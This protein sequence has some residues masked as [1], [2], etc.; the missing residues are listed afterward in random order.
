MVATAPKFISIV[1]VICIVC[2]QHL[3]VSAQNSCDRPGCTTYGC[4]IGPSEPSPAPGPTSSVF[5]GAG[6]GNSATILVP[7]PDAGGAATIPVM[8]SSRREFVYA[9]YFSK[10]AAPPSNIGTRVIFNGQEIG[11]VNYQD[12]VSH[13]SEFTF[14]VPVSSVI[15]GTAA[16]P[17]VNTFQLVPITGCE[18]DCASGCGQFWNFISEE[19]AWASLTVP[20]PVLIR[21]VTFEEVTDDPLGGA[22]DA[23]PDDT[24]GGRRIFPDAEL[25]GPV[26]APTLNEPR[27]KVRVVVQASG[28]TA[29]REVFL[30][31]FDVD[32]S[33]ITDP[34]DSGEKLPGV[35][36]TG[37][38]GDNQGPSVRP[39]DPVPGTGAFA[40]TGTAN[41]TAVTDSTGQALA[42]FLVT[43]QPGDN[44]KIAVGSDA[45]LVDR[46]VVQGQ[47]LADS[48]TNQV[49]PTTN[50]NSPNGDDLIASELLTVWRKM[51]V[52]VDSMAPPPAF[53]ENANEQRNHLAGAIVR[54]ERGGERSTRLYLNP[55]PTAA[56]EPPAPGLAPF[57]DLSRNLSS[58]PA[59][60]GRFQN[61]RVLI[62]D[63]EYS[64]IGNGD[65]YI[66]GS[67]IRIGYNLT[68]ASTTIPPPLPVAG[69]VVS[70]N[71]VPSTIDIDRTL[72][73]NYGGGVVRLSGIDYMVTAVANDSNGRRRRLVV[74]AAPTVPFYNLIDD[75]YQFALESGYTLKAPPSL[76]N[77]PAG[78][79][80]QGNTLFAMMQTSDSYIVTGPRR[81][82][83]AANT[84]ASAF[85]LPVYDLAAYNV[86]SVRP[87]ERNVEEP[88]AEKLHRIT[89]YQDVSSHRD[90]WVVYLAGGFQ[91]HTSSD[92]DS[93][94]VR[95][96]QGSEGWAGG[97]TEADIGIGPPGTGAYII[98]DG[99]IGGAMVYFE[100]DRE[101][102]AANRYP[103]QR[104]LKVSIPHEVGHQFALSDNPGTANIM[105]QGC[106]NQA[107]YFSD[108]LRRDIRR[109][110]HPQ[111]RD[112]VAPTA[113]I[114]APAN[115][116]TVSGTITVA[117]NGSDNVEV[118]GAVLLVDGVEVFVLG[119]P[120]PFQFALNTA[121]L[122]SG[123]HTLVVTTRDAAG[124]VG[125]SAPVVVAIP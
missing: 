81:D 28:T 41:A 120:G 21:S 77:P 92:L 6:A 73:G 55:T 56:T 4:E 35:F 110:I 7:V 86:R 2:L 31:A 124:N 62:D 122:T 37:T 17:G 38:G 112:V 57:T 61:G 36:A 33:E 51:H 102:E 53:T 10:V 54:I 20:E 79:D 5:V 58:S 78:V 93:D 1:V 104:C 101:W 19:L 111:G 105:H 98:P 60:P 107:I 43:M 116:A 25:S 42:I 18:G 22:L 49:L 103:A 85:L 48:A 90:F 99:F 115:N 80:A 114:T 123:S 82:R 30:R 32:D 12:V 66:D 45:A 70:M 118:V 65:D 106:D 91:G 67:R 8:W 89:S 14:D 97:K 74:A 15:F 76:V 23:N 50:S 94:V 87:F 40:L 16:N 52:E 59:R 113:N 75:D 84:F 109:R 11:F 69:I 64:V 26:E 121:T 39:N 34:T 9:L 44:F 95:N 29:G 72:I 117:A 13:Q 27:R 125:I 68:P 88:E 3:T 47:N 108:E 71:L 83:T 46:V 63:N 119:G 96:A 24:G 100:A